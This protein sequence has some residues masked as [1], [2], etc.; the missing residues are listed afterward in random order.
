MY[1]FA[2]RFEF[3][4]S[5]GLIHKLNPPARKIDRHRG[6]CYW[7]MSR[8]APIQT[9]PT[10]VFRPG[11]QILRQGIS[12]DV[13]QNREQVLIL[14]DQRCLVAAL[15]KSAS[16]PVLAVMTAHVR[17]EQPAD[18]VCD[19]A[20]LAWTD[21]Q[22]YVIWHQANS[23]E[24]QVNS[25]LRIAHQCQKSSVIVVVVK[26]PSFLIA[27]VDDVVALICC[28]HPRGASHATRYRERHV[29]R[30]T[31]ISSHSLQIAWEG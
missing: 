7:R 13:S 17:R 10:P 15:P 27:T 8:P 2:H 20:V 23:E 5:H 31:R 12:L 28:D 14:L 22:V 9:S 30:A 4:C 11:D 24:W 6:Q 26:D 18:P 1:R 21:D 3:R 19:I 29:S 16:R 25:I